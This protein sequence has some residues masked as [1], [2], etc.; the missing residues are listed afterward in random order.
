GGF[1]DFRQHFISLAQLLSPFWG[2]GYAGINGGDQ[3]SLQLGV[4][5]L[6]LSVL[7]LFLLG[8]RAPALTRSHILFFAVTTLAAVLLMLPVSAP[9]WGLAAPVVAFVQFPWR[10]LIVTAVALAVLAGAAILLAPE[11]DRLRAAILLSILCTVAL[12]PFAR[13]QY[14]EAVFNN[15]TLMD[16]QVKNREL[17]GDTIWMAPGKR[18][19]D[20]PLVAQYRAGAITEKAVGVEG[21]AVVTLVAHR[22]Q[23]DEVSVAASGPARIMFYTHYFPGWTATVNGIPAGVTPFGEQ[24]LLSVAV[25]DGASTVRVQFGDTWPR[26]VGGIISLVSIAAALGVLLRAAFGIWPAFQL[27]AARQVSVP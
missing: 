6:V 16:F 25:P 14:S 3:F 20:S 24:G 11:T 13:P 19:Q 9:L 1:F 17:L 18:P 22:S 21:N 2:Y 8:R 27:R 26:Q 10:L 12:F 7:S 23:N 15:N 5:P 4:I